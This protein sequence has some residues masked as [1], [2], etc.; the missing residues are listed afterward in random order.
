V[1]DVIM[2]AATLVFFAASFAFVKWLDW[3]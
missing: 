3:I 2:L 1:L